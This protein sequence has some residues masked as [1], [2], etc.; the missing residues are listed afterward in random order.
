MNAA[1][2][3]R[4]P[5]ADTMFVDAKIAFGHR[6]LAIVDLCGGAQPMVDAASGDAL[7]FNG[8]IFGYQRLAAALRA[9][10]VVFRDRSDTE[11][12]FQLLRHHGVSRTL[13]QIDGQFAFAFRDGATGALHLVRD[14]FGEKPLYYGLARRQL[15][16]ASEASAL[17]AHP[18]F[19]HTS[20]DR[21]AAYQFLSFEYLPGTASG[22]DGIAKIEPGSIVTFSNGDLRTERYWRPQLVPAAPVV[23]EQTATDELDALL[24]ASVRDRLVADVPVGVFLS[25]GIDSSLIT[26]LAVRAAPNITG[27]TVR[28][29]GDNFD[30]TPHAIAV[31]RFLGLRHEVV[32]LEEE[33]LLD[34]CDAIGDKL[35]EPLGDSSLLP[36]YLVCRAARRLMT[37]ALGGDGADELFAGYPNFLVQRFAPAMRLVPTAFGRLAGQA[38]ESLPRRSLPRG[39]GYMNWPFIAAQLAQGLGEPTLRQSF[40]WMAP[41]APSAMSLLWK[42]AA[43]PPGGFDAAFAPIERRAADAGALRGVERLL[44][45]FL[46]TYLPE[47]IL[48]K[49]DRASMFNSLEVRAPFLDRA[50]S[51]YACALPT[52]LKLNG[53]RRKYLL[54]LLARRYLPA[55]IVERKKHGFAI[56]IGR[57]IRTL[58]RERCRDVLLSCGNPVAGWFDR[59]AIERMLDAHLSG[60][61]ELGKKLWSL[62]VLFA[63]A[64][65]RP[66]STLAA[67]TVAARQTAFA[68]E[69]PHV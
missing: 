51:A 28:I 5:D 42:R 62:Y 64:A 45:L 29:G 22:W 40:L 33:D 38:I 10:G 48:T 16:F 4:G 11:V 2:A 8:E 35:V 17:L 44:Y 59:A 50:F 58:F 14:R 31:A 37:V 43:L 21:L 26:A 23:D 39:E 65:R 7:V 25:G 32:T 20:P 57:Y 66:Q 34:A 63:V 30:E 41:F 55:E 46:T 47:D 60:R 67:P 12:L 24:T 54:K 18:A 13:E 9:D 36:T 1:L 56:P 49:T 27:F 15:V 61:Q 52:A 53:G 68:K 69:Y 19:A 6:R 3:H